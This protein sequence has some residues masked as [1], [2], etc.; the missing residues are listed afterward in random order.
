MRHQRGIPREQ[1]RLLPAS[2][3]DY[4]AADHPVR[5]IDAF[6]DSVDLSALEFAQARPAATGRPPYPPGDLLKRFLY[7]YLHQVRATRRLEREASRNLALWWLL[8]EL[9]PDFKTLANFRRAHGGAIGQVCRAFSAFCRG[10]G[11]FGAELVAID[12]SRC[13]AVAS[14]KQVWTPQRVAKMQARIA[15]KIGEYLDALARSEAEASP[16]DE[17]AASQVRAAL[18]AL[19]ARRQAVAALAHSAKHRLVAGEREAKLMRMAH[20]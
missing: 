11:L 1:P 20:G 9:R 4:V 14:R 10:Q 18:A 6:I 8:G 7:E 15:Q 13:Q 17:T 2:I 12:G 19:E 16:G 5:V 3:E